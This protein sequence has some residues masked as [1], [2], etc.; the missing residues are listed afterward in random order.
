VAWALF[1]QKH[2]GTSEWTGFLEHGVKLEGKL[3]A[4]GMFRIDSHMKGTVVSRE[5]LIVGEKA[6]VEGEI[7]GN[8]VMISGR[9]DGTIH[10][11]GKVEIQPKAIVTGEVHAPC[12][13][14]EPG[15]VFDG[16]C[17]MVLQGG[18]SA[19]AIPIPIRSAVDAA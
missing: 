8:N 2:H 15:A 10:A 18:E 1:D 16:Q 12:L 14:I 3:E 11:T 9:F 13:I 17:H 7:Q 5:T 19:P 6:A 4:P